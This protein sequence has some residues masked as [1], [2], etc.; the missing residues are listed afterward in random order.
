[1]EELSEDQ[2]LKFTIRNLKTVLELKSNV[3][4]LEKNLVK[5][6]TITLR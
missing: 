4:L 2:I 1:M 5:I 6:E 3:E